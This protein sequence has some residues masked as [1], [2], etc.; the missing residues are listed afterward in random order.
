MKLAAIYNVFDGLELLEKSINSIRNEVD[1]IVVVY[2]EISNFNIKSNINIEKFLQNIK[3]IDIIYKYDTDLQ[4]PPHR[5][6]LLKRS[7]GCKIALEKKCT[8]FLHVDCDE[9]YK[10]ESFKAAKNIICLNDYDSTACEIID[11]YKFEDLQVVNKQPSY[12]PF[13]H[14]L[15]KGITKFGENLN[16]PLLV[17]STRKCNP[18]EKFFLF[19]KND[20]VMHHLS[21]I[22]DDI[23]IKLLNS[24]AR[25]SYNH[26][27]DLIVQEFNDFKKGDKLV[28]LETGLLVP[29]S[30]IARNINFR[31]INVET[32][33]EV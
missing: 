12:V 23:K 31:F 17:D 22:R 29:N 7:T 6:E 19:E 1:L 8:H 15:Q 3:T 24:T 5:N 32:N 13:I 27:L 33:I 20:L 18:T 4:L 21:W 28:K 26:F 9:L 25:H 30:L 16:Y 2:Q 10:E 14:K 11:Y